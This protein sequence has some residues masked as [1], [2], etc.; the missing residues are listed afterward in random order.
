MRGPFTW[1][2][3]TETI[4]AAQT[5]PYFR[6]ADADDN[7]VAQC[8]DKDNAMHISACLNRCWL[9]DLAHPTTDD[10]RRVGVVYAPPRRRSH[11]Q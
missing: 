3:E 9:S 10:A 6:I 7:N 2:T 4:N 11:D 1:S 5:V 8:Y